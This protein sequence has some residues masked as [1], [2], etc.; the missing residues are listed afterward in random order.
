M[1]SRPGH[2]VLDSQDRTVTSDSQNRTVI[3]GLT[4]E[5]R[6]ARTEQV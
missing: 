5:D 4:G 3:R 2:P 1:T 6:I